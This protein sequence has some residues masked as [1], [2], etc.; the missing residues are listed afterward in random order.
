MHFATLTLLALS[1][2]D[3]FVESLPFQPQDGL[4]QHSRRRAID[5]PIDSNN[6]AHIRQRI[7]RR[8][9]NYSVVQVDG[10]SSSAPSPSTLVETVTR[11]DSVTSPV[12]KTVVYTTVLQ[13]SVSQETVVMTTTQELP[14]DTV[15]AQAI[16]TNFI[17]T[18]AQATNTVTD[19]VMTTAAT[20]VL[21]THSSSST[22]YYD[23]GQWHTYYPVKN[24]VPPPLAGPPNDRRARGAEY[25]EATSALRLGAAYPSEWAWKQ[26][27]K[28]R[29]A[30]GSPQVAYA[31]Y[32]TKA[33]YARGV[34]APYPTHS[35]Y[36]KRGLYGTPSL[37]YVAPHAAVPTALAIDANGAIETEYVFKRDET[38]PQATAYAPRAA[39]PTQPM[40]IGISG[41]AETEYVFKRDVAAPQ[42]TANVPRAAMPKPMDIGIGGAAET[43]YI[44]KRDLVAPQ[45]TAHAA[46]AAMPNPVAVGPDGAIE[47]EYVFKR[48]VTSSQDTEKLDSEPRVAARKAPADLKLASWDITP[49]QN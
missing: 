36:M 23:D 44:F 11:K 33:V 17:E 14:P 40:D 43:E 35:P 4:L 15:T 7:R 19:T 47:T 12:T 13:G 42:A 28:K 37:R 3:H 22:S 32:S 41:A 9:V 8:S 2:I 49:P 1:S 24:F 48:D 10:G 20:P 26:H 46:R 21:A 38:A 31:A 27:V 29:I 45:A 18:G 16:S 6:P 25:A 5:Y 39:M 34:N 30:A